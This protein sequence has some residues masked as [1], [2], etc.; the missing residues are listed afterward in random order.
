MQKKFWKT[1]RW[2]N[3]Y[4]VKF[5]YCLFS[6]RSR[7]YSSEN[8]C[9][10]TN[11][12]WQ[13]N[14][15]PDKTRDRLFSVSNYVTPWLFTILQKRKAIKRT[16][17]SCI[18]TFYSQYPVSC[19]FSTFTSTLR[20]KYP[21]EKMLQ[22]HKCLYCDAYSFST[23]TVDFFTFIFFSLIAWNLKIV[24]LKVLKTT[25]CFMAL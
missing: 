15:T 18:L 1:Q 20:L 23:K 4:Q 3:W 25:A 12:I 5:D 13:S 8:G 17:G 2:K 14:K 6:V 21:K 11:N 19:K 24:C 7:N 22:H 16:E 9:S 10:H